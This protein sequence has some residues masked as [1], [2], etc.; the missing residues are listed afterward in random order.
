[1]FVLSLIFYHKNGEKS[2]IFAARNPL[3][4]WIFRVSQSANNSYKGEISSEVPDVIKRNFYAEKHNKKWLTD[5]TEFSIPAGKVY[6][7]PIIDCCSW[8]NVT[9]EDFINQ[10]DEYMRWYRDKRIKMS[11]GALSP[12]EYRKSLGVGA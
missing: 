4:C 10:I 7:S 3:H 6:L 8:L 1:M 5:I 2:D 9:V 12:M 11:L